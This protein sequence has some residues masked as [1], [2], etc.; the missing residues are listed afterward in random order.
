MRLRNTYL[1]GAAA[2]LQMGSQVLTGLVSIPLALH[3]LSSQQFGLWA[4]VSQSLGYLLLLDLGVG[5]SLARLLAE[6]LHVGNEQEW[7]GWFNLALIV[8][9]IQAVLVLGIGLLLVDP[10]LRWF[11]IPA[12]L[13]PQARELWLIV[14]V[15]NA[16]L[17]PLRMFRG[18][19]GAQNRGYWTFG[20]SVLG[21]WGGL[22]AFYIFLKAGWGVLAYGWLA[23]VQL[24]L[25]MGLPMAATLWGPHRFRLSWRNI[26][27]R[28]LRE[29]FGFS[30]ALFVIS[31]AVQIVFMSQSLVIT[32]I[33]GLAAVASFTV[34][35][36]V[37]MLLMQAIWQPFD[38]FAPR[39]Q[40]Y[41]AKGQKAA[42]TQEYRRMSR[43]TMGLAAAGAVCC[44]A[45]NRWF[46]F[47][48]GKESLYAGK[49][50]DFFFAVFVMLSVWGHCLGISFVLAKRMKGLAVVAVAGIPIFLTI[51]V[52]G[53]KLH[54]LTGYIAFTTCWSLIG[55]GSW[56]QNLKGPK[57]LGLRFRSLFRE[58]AP[59]VVVFCVLMGIGWLAFHEVGTGTHLLIAETALS[60]AAL[61]WFLSFF[62]QDLLALFHRLQQV[63]RNRSTA[64]SETPPAA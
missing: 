19:V 43:F 62:R 45:M 54:G 32:K 50:F 57:Q 21:A 59:N 5:H 52:V 16:V 56:Y 15:L 55:L 18:I 22:L 61:A 12:S 38:A 58:Q 37:P 42:L 40:I 53:T 6:P 14:L 25:T 51:A 7:N 2:Y 27:W 60:I 46:V 48:F 11:P 3:F 30:S 8:L 26:P 34:C 39:W 49:T 29:L 23:A 47:I 35:S 31:I 64:R 36:R 1:T 44:F 28:H 10:I 13:F 63:W 4:F 17:Y 24:C 9:T 33:L 20:G 41:W